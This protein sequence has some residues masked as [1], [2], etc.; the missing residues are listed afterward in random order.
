[1]T[2][3]ERVAVA[4]G[5][6]LRP[7]WAGVDLAAIRSNARLLA[8][9][10]APAALCAV[11]KADGYGHGALAVAR[12]ALSG[13]ARWLA[14]ALVEEGIELR[15][16]GIA[17]PILVLS[18]PHPDAMAAV[19]SYRLVPTLYTERGLAAAASAVEAAAGGGGAGGG[20]P[21][22][23]Y[24]AGGGRS[25]S[26][27]P[28]Q[29]KVDTGMHRVGAQ[30]AEAVRLAVE[31]AR[32][33]A[34]LLGGFFTH[35]AVADEP[36]SPFTGRQLAA[37]LGACSQLT[38]AGVEAGLRHAANSAGALWHPDARLDM[39]R[40]GIALYGLSP[41][42]AGGPH[43]DG[44][45]PAMSLRAQ[46]SYVKTVEAGECLSYGLR[47][48]LGERSVVATVPI[49][50]ADGVPRRLGAV[51][52]QVLIRGRRLPIAG[53]VTM[54]QITVDCG[55]PGS[56]PEVSAGDEVVLI[57]SQGD[58]T[59]SAWEWAR[60]TDTIAYEVVCGISQR[61]PRVYR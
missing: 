28:V 52:G 8:R 31:V 6:G 45:V 11:V 26:P 58:E 61:V 51:G 50:Y 19:V 29:V 34:L 14:V 59:I 12:A 54:D 17:A 20:S 57:G 35:F 43:V 25:A 22:G 60:L 30:P 27:L 48:R 56:H 32:H 13:G 2:S 41:N 10:A 5:V 49:G 23:G 44:L 46:V 53:T 37:Y 33:P 21:G 18:E 40:C 16:G 42:A 36:E 4:G 3:V 24:G 1:V 39:V 47:Y 55:P 15:E 9:V 38:A 7:V